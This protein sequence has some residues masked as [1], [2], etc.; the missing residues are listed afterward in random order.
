MGLE[1]HHDVFLSQRESIEKLLISDPENEK[2][3]RKI[4][5]FYIKEARDNLVAAAPG[6]LHMT[7]DPRGAAHSIR[8]S[9]YKSVLGAQINILSS[10]KRGQPTSYEP[11]R[12][13]RPHQR[14]GNRVPQGPNTARMMSYGPHD[15]GMVLRWLNNGTGQ[16]TAGSRG[17]RLHGNRGCIAPRNWCRG[18]AE[19]E[20]NMAAQRI[21]Q[22][23]EEELVKS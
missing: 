19:Q 6:G 5:Q 22:M 14:G 13:L 11:T 3:I 9:V 12:T 7:S 18:A 20:L 1:V 10:R 23:I 4:I 16:R 15:R 17:G 21:A 2:R 8:R